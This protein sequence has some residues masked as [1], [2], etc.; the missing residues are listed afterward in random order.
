MAYLTV[1][2]VE[3]ELKVNLGHYVGIYL[4][5]G[6]KSER[7]R[8]NNLVTKHLW[9]KKQIVDSYD[10]VRVECVNFLTKKECEH[11]LCKVNQE[12]IDP[13]YGVEGL[14]DVVYIK[15]ARTHLRGVGTSKKYY[16]EVIFK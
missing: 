15:D 11:Y 7:L 9:L 10:P 3:E 12:K 16:A 6:R 2:S 4:S 1:E 14:A 5:K 13:S 8:V